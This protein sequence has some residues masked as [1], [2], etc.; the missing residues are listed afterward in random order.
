MDF[1]YSQESLAISQ[2]FLRAIFAYFI[3]LIAVKLLGQRTISQLRL[4]D[5]IIA[6]ILGNILA[7][8]LSDEG[9][10]MAGS[11]AT[12]FALVVMYFLS[13]QLKLKFKVFEKFLSPAPIPLVKNGE[14]IYKN[15][16]KAKISLDF[17]LS[18]LRLQNVADVKKIAVAFW[19]PG[20]KISVFLDS[21]HQ[22]LTPIDMQ[23]FPKPFSLPVV[24]IK[25]GDIDINALHDIN[26]T[27]D[28]LKDL[29]KQNY[30]AEVKDILLA[31]VDEN[32][33]LN[34]FFKV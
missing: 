15:L 13:L 3:L 32:F 1:F 6:I 9:L 30:S 24:V 33:T 20:G 8:P 2:W 22:P 11:I 23:I 25:E 5:F 10:G 21:T 7:H 18:E 29:L 27:K 26:R 31:T 4:L 12:T 17:L 19:E 34:V 14:I 28:W 16:V